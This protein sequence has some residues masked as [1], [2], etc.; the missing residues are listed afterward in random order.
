M[1]NKKEE[2][3]RKIIADW[4]PLGEKSSTIKDLSGYKYE[5]MDIMSSF[6]IVPGLS[7]KDAIKSVIEGAFNIILDES[8]LNTISEKI[9]KILS[10]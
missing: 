6:K 4:N 5:A 8:E 9:S 1:S 10:K 7:L 2:E 3:V